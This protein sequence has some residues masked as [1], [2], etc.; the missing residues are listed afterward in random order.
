[1]NT[2]YFPFLNERPESSHIRF[3]PCH[4]HIIYYGVFICIFPIENIEHLIYNY[5]NSNILFVLVL[6]FSDLQFPP[7]LSFLIDTNLH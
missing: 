6:Y 3:S 1:M 5:G 7:D 2:L 4:L